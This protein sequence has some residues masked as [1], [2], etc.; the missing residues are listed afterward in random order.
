MTTKVDYDAL[1]KEYITGTMS[2]REMAKTHDMSWS[3]VASQ[4]RRRGWSEKREAYKDSV[5]KRTYEHAADR[6]AREKAEIQSENVIA[7]RATVRAFIAQLQ[8]GEI[9]VSAKDATEAAKVL[10]MWMGE[11]TSRTE[12]KV[13][14]FTTGGLEP[15]FLRR[16]AEIARAR[17]VEGTTSEPPRSL[18]EGARED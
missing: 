4:A 3:A 16:L 11:P 13:I 1:E 10:S 5:Q 17:I 12:S 14:E 15:E 8:A 18:P 9:K 7:L 2:L 6:Y